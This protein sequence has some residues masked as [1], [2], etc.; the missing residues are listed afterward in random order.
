MRHRPTTRKPPFS[1]KIK[2]RNI[3]L[4]PGRDGVI[5]DGKGNVFTPQEAY[6]LY[7]LGMV[8][9]DPRIKCKVGNYVANNRLRA[10]G[11]G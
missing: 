9:L 11:V 8:D 2:P 6:E 5:W 7:I 1:R 3:I 10:T 4:V